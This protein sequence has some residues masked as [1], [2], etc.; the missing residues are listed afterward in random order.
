MSFDDLPPLPP[1]VHPEAE[2]Y[3]RR[4]MAATRRVQ[5]ASRVLIDCRYGTDYWQKLDVYLPDKA[6]AK[7]PVLIF[8]HGGAWTGGTKEW[9]GFMAPPLLA[10]PAIFVTPNYRLAPAVRY[11]EM[12]EDCIAAVAWVQ[13]NVVQHGGDPRRIFVGGHSAGGH[14]AA[15]VALDRERRRRAGIAEDAIQGCLAVSGSF[16]IRNRN[17]PAGTMERRIYDVLLRQPS[18]DDAASPI[19]HVG[20]GAVPFFISWGTR[21]FPRLVRQANA[22]AAA[23]RAAGV[24]VETLAI[25][26]AD[27]FEANEICGDANSKWVQAAR[28]WLVQ[29]RFELPLAPQLR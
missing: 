1:P 16:D 29:S 13:E 6:A 21:D 3:A 25:D 19:A 23:L 7:L 8:F 10:I 20:P 17:A 11:P 14:M 18:D 9:M 2:G 22:M 28:R 4:C 5:A 12:L 26:D 15:L 27:H 24:A